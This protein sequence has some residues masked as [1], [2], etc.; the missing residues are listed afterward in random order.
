MWSPTIED[1]SLDLPSFFMVAGGGLMSSI[2][3]T[4]PPKSPF[5]KGGL[6]ARPCLALLRNLKHSHI[7]VQ[8]SVR[9][10]DMVSYHRGQIIR[11]VL[12]FYRSGGR[13]DVL[14]HIYNLPTAS[15][16]GCALGTPISSSRY[17]T[18]VYISF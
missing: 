6:V 8:Q 2:I 18:A 17:T 12:F 3:F 1:K 14:S 7:V 15:G 4:F 9:N 11:F 5:D 10:F 13:T 16:Y